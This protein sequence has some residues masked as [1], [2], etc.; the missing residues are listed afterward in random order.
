M[1]NTGSSSIKFAVFTSGGPIQSWS[2]CSRVRWKFGQWSE[3]FQTK[4]VAG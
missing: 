3:L 1:I 4:E 2:C